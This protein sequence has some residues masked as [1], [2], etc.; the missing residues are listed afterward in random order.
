[1]Q[2]NL[3]VPILILIMWPAI[4]RH[5]QMN[6]QA[7]ALTAKLLDHKLKPTDEIVLV[8]GRPDSSIEYYSGLHIQR[9]INEIEMAGIGKGRGKRSMELYM[10]FVDRINER[11]AK[12]HPVYMILSAGS[13]HMLL[14]NTNTQ[15]DVLFHLKG[16]EKDPEDEPI[17][18]TQK[19]FHSPR[20]QAAPSSQPATATAAGR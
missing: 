17:V 4:G 15:A 8:D 1:L 14:A 9:L 7:D 2:L 6:G 5:V 20:G 18:I 3:G 11:L 10:A 16:F 12:N 13:Y 19:R